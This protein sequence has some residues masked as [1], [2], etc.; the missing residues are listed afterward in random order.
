M[1]YLLLLLMVLAWSGNF[2]VAKLTLREMPPLTLLFLRIWMA[3]AILAALYLVSQR[4][5]RPRLR[6]SDWKNFVL[7]GVLGVAANQAGFI[8]GI[9]RT[10]V[11]HSSLIVSLCPVFV[12]ILAT[13]MK[14]EPLT[15]RKAVGMGLCLCGAAVL[16]SEHGSGASRPTLG[17]DLLTLGGTSAFALY[18]VYSKR[19]S[20]RYHTLTLNTFVYAAGAL[21]VTPLAGWQAF[22]SP[23]ETVTWRGWLGVVYMALIGSVVAY[24]IFYYGL[25]RLPA[26]RVIVL[27]YLQPVVATTL[28][29]FGLGE[30]TTPHLIAGGVLILTGVYLAE[31]QRAATFSPPSHGESAGGH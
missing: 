17:G 1:L 13:R 3:C 27:T 2:V 23:W 5:R 28:G 12:L 31:R 16:A 21:V 22:T 18:T 24:L 7:L 10:T 4:R 30:E 14:L 29:I 8:T 19:I 20:D 25:T 9:Q 6:A 15:W 26:S 11:G